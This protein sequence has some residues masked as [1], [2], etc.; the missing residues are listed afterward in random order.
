V[1][2]LAI[3]GVPP[4][5]GVF[6]KEAILFAAYKQH[7]WLY[8]VALVT[9][10]ITS[11]C[12]FRLYFSIFWNK[13]VKNEHTHEGNW[14]IKLPLLILI[15]LVIVTGFIPFGNFISANGKPLQLPM[16]IGFSVIPVLLALLG[17][18]YAA[19]LYFKES[20]VPASLENS[21]GLVYSTVKHKFY[22]DELYQFMTH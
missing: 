14:L 17:I 21:F 15:A 8:A 20:N 16:H 9:A 13:P 22:I 7:K 2:C 10:F 11:Y 6:S 12:M 5:S 4:F 1:G 19:I 18:V 3:A